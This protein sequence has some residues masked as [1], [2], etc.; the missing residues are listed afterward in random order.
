MN[1]IPVGRYPAPVA[2]FSAKGDFMPDAF[3]ELLRYFL[4]NGA[5]GLLIAGDN[6]EAWSLSLDEIAE[7]TRLAM[8]AAQG[9]PVYVSAWAITAYST[10]VRLAH[11]HRN[12]ATMN[13]LGCGLN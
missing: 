13:T 7:M 1:R 11:F 2:P 3:A 5:K 8:D 10:G 6:A 9:K 12:A 4:D